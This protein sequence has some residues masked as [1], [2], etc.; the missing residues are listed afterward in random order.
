MIDPATF[1]AVGQSVLPSLS[2]GLGGGTEQ[3]DAPPDDMSSRATG[4]FSRGDVIVGTD[5]A[6]KAALTIVI[7]LLGVQIW[8]HRG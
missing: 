4:T 5:K 3:A 7:V 6:L 8:R 2:S 1:M